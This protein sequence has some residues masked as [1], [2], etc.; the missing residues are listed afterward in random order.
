MFD[1][2]YSVFEFFYDIIYTFIS[3]FDEV[4]HIP[5]D[6]YDFQLGFGQV[7]WFSIPLDDF[8]IFIWFS[9]IFVIFIILFIRIIKWLFSIPKKLGGR[10]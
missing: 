7:V 4:L 1:F 5:L 2:I 9:F 10:L 3:Y 6:V 8:M